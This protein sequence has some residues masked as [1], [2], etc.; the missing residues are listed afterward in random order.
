MKISWVTCDG[1]SWMDPVIDCLRESGHEVAVNGIDRTF[2]VLFG[3]TITVQEN[4]YRV[5]HMF[6]HIPMV[7]YNWD[8]YEWAYN[9]VDPQSFPYNIELYAH[10]LKESKFVAC[11][12]RSVVHRNE[13][14]FQIP[15]DQSVIVKSF[16]RQINIEPSKVR[17]D[18]FVY[19][20]LRQIPDR[21]KG[22]FEKACQ[23]LNIPYRLPN[24]ELSEEDYADTVASCSFLVCPWYEA[25][26]G[27]LSLIEGATVGKPILFCDSKYMGA[28]D[29]L[30]KYAVK[31]KHDDYEDFKAKLKS[32]WDNPTT[33]KMSQEDIDSFKPEVMA[34]GLEELFK[35]CIHE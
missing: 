28:E 18:R 21:N 30:G 25:S 2:D 35:R 33:V 34:K 22:W 8:V 17:D 1:A 6:P 19:M 32:M 10:L 16:A 24:K 13:E 7:N 4:I 14:F 3:S 20:P 11:P 27:G 29:Y 9:K 26:T 23:E 12:S 15:K 5:H 31:F